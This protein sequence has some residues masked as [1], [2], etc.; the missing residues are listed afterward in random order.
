M[1]SELYNSLHNAK[2]DKLANVQDAVTKCMTTI[3]QQC[4]SVMIVKK[5]SSPS[6]ALMNISKQRA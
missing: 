1:G 4:V 5:H 6:L 2:T 3:W